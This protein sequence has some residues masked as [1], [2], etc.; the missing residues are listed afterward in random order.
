MKTRKQYLNNE[1][2]HH[3]YYIQFV[4]PLTRTV[5]ANGIGIDRIKG[6]TDPHLNDIPL[7]EWDSLPIN[8]YYNDNAMKAAGDYLTKSG[9]VCIAK[10]AARE[11]AQ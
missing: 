4:T 2:S 1:C 11:I 8:L 7:A 5:V 10:A 9:A 6:S 3:E